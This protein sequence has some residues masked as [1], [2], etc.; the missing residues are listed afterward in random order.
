MVDFLVIGAGITGLAIAWELHR[1]GAQVMVCDRN[2]NQAAALAAAGMLA[3]Q[4]EKLPPGPMFELCWR[5][6]MLYRD[7]INQIEQA[8]SLKTGYWESGILAPC[9]Q[10]QPNSLGWRDRL[11]LEQYCPGLGEA[12]VGGY[13]YPEDAQV[14][15]RS[16]H[17]S[18]RVA[19]VNAG[20]PLHQVEV[21]DIDYSQGAITGLRTNLGLIRAE[22]YILAT[23]AW[24]QNLIDIPVYPKKGQMLSVQMPPDLRIKTVLYGEEVYLVPRQDGRL[25]IGATVE[26]VDF[27]PGN[28]PQGINQLL[29]AALRLYPALANAPIQ[30]MWWGFRPASPDEMPI[31]GPSLYTNLTLATGH[32]RNGILLAPIT[33]QLIAE[34]LSTST[35][36]ELLSAFSWQ[37]F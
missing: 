32:Y 13:W 22:H 7:W 18:L 9:Y 25:I 21:K 14:D 19:V 31:L 36:P 2:P 27:L 11:T 16:L 12:V 4:A 24:S 26:N 1:R 35:P 20:V 5:S 8:T 17:H 23:G 3:P 6:L 29:G 15:N 30:E 37:R 10:T 34:Y 28:T 33:A